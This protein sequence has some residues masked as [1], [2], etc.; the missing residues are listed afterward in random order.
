MAAQP[1]FVKLNLIQISLF[2]FGMRKLIFVGEIT[3]QLATAPI[4]GIY[5]FIYTL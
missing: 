5:I 2:G 4:D 3:R 1:N